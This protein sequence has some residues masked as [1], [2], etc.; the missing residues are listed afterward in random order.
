MKINNLYGITF[1]VGLV[2]IILDQASKLWVRLDLLSICH[3]M[4]DSFKA[5]G[6]ITIRCEQV[7]EVFPFLNIRL[8][9]NPGFSFS[10]FANAGQ[11]GRWV[12]IAAAFVICSFLLY[13]LKK[14]PRFW[15]AL[16]IGLIVGGALG[17]VIDRIYIGAVVDFIDFHIGD[18]HPFIFNIADIEVFLGVCCV[19][20]DDLFVKSKKS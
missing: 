6:K 16:G 15:K 7:I 18:F 11:V 9:L 3:P 1:F 17:N 14:E 10:A 2:T 8:H 20:T 4:I 12:L 13:Y 5:T 19:L